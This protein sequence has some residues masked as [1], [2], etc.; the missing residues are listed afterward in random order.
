[1][2]SRDVDAGGTSPAWFRAIVL[3]A[4]LATS[5]NASHE[6]ALTRDAGVYRVTVT[7]NGWLQR[8]FFV[9]TGAADV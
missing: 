3:V 4:A 1:M 8:P 5:A 7:M 2:A 9:D 6:I